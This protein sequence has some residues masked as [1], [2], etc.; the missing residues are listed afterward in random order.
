MNPTAGNDN[1]AELEGSLPDL[2][3]RSWEDFER[4]SGL[5]QRDVASDEDS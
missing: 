2:P 3:E 4:A 1:L 5:A